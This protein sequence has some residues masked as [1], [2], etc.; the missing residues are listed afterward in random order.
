MGF[1]DKVKTAAKNADTKLGN[2]I[3]KEKIDSKIRE[4]E[5]VIKD[6]TAEIGKKIVEA[7]KDGKTAADA[8]ISDL[9][10]RIRTAE[11]KISDYNKQKEDIDKSASSEKEEKKE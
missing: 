8:D 7:L 1:V 9:Y 2:S 11:A 4:E 3:D 10:Q 6:S 5:K